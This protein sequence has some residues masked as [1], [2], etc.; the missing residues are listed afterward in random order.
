MEKS[1]HSDRSLFDLDY[2]TRFDHYYD[3][4]KYRVKEVLV[5]S[6]L[7]DDFVVEESK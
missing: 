1:E 7:Y 2:A 4:I 6:S 5:V 3:L